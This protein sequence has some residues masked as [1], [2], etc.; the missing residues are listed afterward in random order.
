MVAAT[1]HRTKPYIY[2]KACIGVVNTV[3]QLL[4]FSVSLGTMRRVLACNDRTE[5]GVAE[6]LRQFEVAV[7]MLHSQGVSQVFRHCGQPR[8]SAYGCTFRRGF[9]GVKRSILHMRVLSCVLIVAQI[10]QS[11]RDTFQT[12]S[13]G[14]SNTPRRC[15]LG[16]L[17]LEGS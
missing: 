13:V 14:S 2:M 17:V 12:S 8:M 16:R 4:N 9:D 6:G 7:G 11:R 1:A 10:W 5:L 3:V 15:G